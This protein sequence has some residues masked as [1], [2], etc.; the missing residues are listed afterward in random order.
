MISTLISD[1][2]PR[3][4]QPPERSSVDNSEIAYQLPQPAGMVPDTFVGSALDLDGDERDWV[5]Q[6]KDARSKSRRLPNSA[7]AIVRPM[8][9]GCTNY[10]FGLVY[11]SK[12]G[13]DR[14]LLDPTGAQR[15][16]LR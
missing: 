2:I 11:P 4:A 6:S 9:R 10:L 1:E 12:A 5:P 16:D 14:S 13:L 7:P 15:M 8:V 3:P